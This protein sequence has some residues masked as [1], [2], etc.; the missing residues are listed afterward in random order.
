VLVDLE[1]LKFLG[2]GVHCQVQLVSEELEL[3]ACEMPVPKD[4]PIIELIVL[5]D[6]R[7]TI[8]QM[9]ASIP[10]Y[11]GYKV[12]DYWQVINNQNLF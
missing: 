4:Y 5:E 6:S 7:A 1:L 3:D 8:E 2:L 10:E 11:Q 9:I 12:F